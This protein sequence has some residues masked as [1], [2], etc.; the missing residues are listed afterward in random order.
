MKRK[1]T[2]RNI[3]IAAAVVV[4]IVAA[5][6]LGI[7][8]R[9]DGH[10][11]N[12]FERT[13]T[14]ASANG[15]S[16]TMLEYTLTLDQ[17]MQSYSSVQLT[18]EQVKAL[19]ENAAAQALLMKIYTREAKA[20]GLQLTDEE[21]AACKSAAQQQIDA[22]VSSYTRQLTDGG[23][24]SKA[25]LDKQIANYYAMLGM[26]QTQYYNFCK[27]RTE[28]SYYMDKLEAYFQTNGSGFTEEEILENYHESVKSTM[29][30][31]TAGQYSS[32]TLMYA[33][34]Y[35][36][37]MLFVPEGFFY[38][39]YIEVSKDTEE[40]VQAIFDKVLN[41][42]EDAMT[43][44]ELMASEDNVNVFKSVLSGPYAIGDED[45]SYLFEKNEEAYEKAKALEIGGIDTFIMPVTKTDADGNETVNGYIGY[46]FRRA[47]G[48]MCEEGQSGIVKI[49]YYPSVRQDVESGLRQK[50]WMSDAVYTDAMYAYRGSI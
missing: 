47:E 23:S 37:P 36:S 19:Q 5:I 24:F 18:D 43:F 29:E 49:D 31:Y 9:K 50:K 48:D 46:M 21:T 2:I 32:T 38:I 14:A 22:V 16:V 7:A 20:L 4:L 40:E 39:D 6:L 30:S 44:D 8:L 45:Y 41:G 27:S 15:E 28:A 34:G 1:K 12:W 3:L 17:I 25:A 26:N 11:M 35:A 10:G 33:Y 42:G 13:R